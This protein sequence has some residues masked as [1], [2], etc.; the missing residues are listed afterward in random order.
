MEMT[1]EM[2]RKLFRYEDGKLFWRIKPA[3]HIDAGD[4]AGSSR[5]NGDRRRFFV[6]YR[7]RPH[8]RARLIWMIHHGEIPEGLVIDHI[9]NDSANDLIDNLQAITQRENRSKD[10]LPN[11][12]PTGVGRQGSKF[13]AEA[14]IDGKKR[15]LG[16]FET[17]E[18]ASAAYQQA[19]LIQVS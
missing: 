15:H 3:N 1:A 9:D 16:T 5:P 2:A 18:E 4:E 17:P 8:P 12:L 14:R 6:A 13:C 7:G 19:I 10:Q 11:G